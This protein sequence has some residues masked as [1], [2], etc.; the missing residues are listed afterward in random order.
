MM[1]Q[2]LVM[3]DYID[4]NMKFVPVLDKDGIVVIYD[5]YRSGKWYGSRRTLQQ[6]QDFMNWMFP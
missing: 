2:G 5:M 6:A 1:L 3:P 4:V